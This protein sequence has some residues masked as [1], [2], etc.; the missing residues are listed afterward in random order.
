MKSKQKGKR[1]E[2]EFARLCREHGY[3]ARRTAQYCGNTGDAS[4]VVGLPGIH[5]EVKRVERLNI[6]EA[7]AQAKNDAKDGKPTIFHRRNNCEWLVTMRAEDWFE[8]YREWEVA[9]A[10]DNRACTHSDSGI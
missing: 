4:D 1:G 2:L 3:N 5:V 8:L 10:H 6:T 7:M 9:N